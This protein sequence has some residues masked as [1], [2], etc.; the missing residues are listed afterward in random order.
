MSEEIKYIIGAYAFSQITALKRF[1]ESPR[2]KYDEGD[3]LKW[4]LNKKT[5][6]G[7]EG[8]MKLFEYFFVHGGRYLRVTVDNQ[9]NLVF[10]FKD[11]SGWHKLHQVIL[12][13][14]KIVYR[15][16]T[17]GLGKV[18]D[19]EVEF[20]PVIKAKNKVLEKAPAW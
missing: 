5:T 7:M 3:I 4:Y 19:W 18:L 15:E 6:E 13:P 10:E 1:I 8:L 12:M 17:T 9:Y 20:I 2:I 14:D 16:I 11:Q